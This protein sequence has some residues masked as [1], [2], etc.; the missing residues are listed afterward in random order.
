MKKGAR[1]HVMRQTDWSTLSLSL[2]W[3]YE[4]DVPDDGRGNT[5]NPDL[6][7]LLLLRGTARITMKDGR[8]VEARKGQWLFLPPGPREQ[9]FSADARILSLTWRAR[10]PDGR[11]LFDRGLPIAVP[12]SEHPELRRAADALMRLV[13]RSYGDVPVPAWRSRAGARI[14]ADV[15]FRGEIRLLQ[16]LGHLV[17]ILGAEGVQPAIH[18]IPDDRLLTALE[19]ME[20]IP[21]RRMPTVPEIAR[22]AGLSESQFKRLFVRHLGHSPSAH[23]RDRCLT[24]ARHLLGSNDLPIKEIAYLLGFPSQSAFYN[25]FKKHEG[26]RPGAVPPVKHPA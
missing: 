21:L 25:W 23:L 12:A 9:I 3:I 7:A 22:K 8:M 2:Q 20:T 16:W 11:P 14:T 19:V 13:D 4:D 26:V 17:R 6:G 15:F 18:D 1:G 5:V 10:W 24:E